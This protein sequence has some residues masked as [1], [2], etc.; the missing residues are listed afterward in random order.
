[1]KYKNGDVLNELDNNI[2]YGYFNAAWTR[3]NDT[4]ISTSGYCFVLAGGVVSWANKKQHSMALSSTESKYMVLSKPAT[5][6]IWLQK[7]L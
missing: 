4:R 2:L 1:M 7:L 6:A 3:D 5:E